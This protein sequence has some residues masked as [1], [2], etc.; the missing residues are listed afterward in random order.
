ML[1]QFWENLTWPQAITIVVALLVLAFI[2]WV[3][4]TYE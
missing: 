1:I 4:K 2:V 3:V